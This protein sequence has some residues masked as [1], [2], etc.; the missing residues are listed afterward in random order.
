MP[1]YKIERW[2]SVIPSG[3][4]FP[5]PMIYIKPDDTFSEY[6]VNNN[7]NFF[8]TISGTNSLYDGNV[9]GMI[10]NSANYPNNRVN[11]YNKTGYYT[12]TLFGNWNGYPPENGEVLIQ[13]VETGP[14]KAI[15]EPPK[16]FEAPKP[17]EW[18]NTADKSDNKENDNL[19]T[20]Q[21]C[22]ILL[23]FLIVFSILLVMNLKR[24][25]N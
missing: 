2:D 15:P 12:I 8:L 7:Y 5:M 1:N 18:Y 23:L 9:I 13:G 19:S 3:N 10:N 16:P 14:D 24:D 11:F 17:L 20:K 22:L 6:V 4:T 25:K 21:L